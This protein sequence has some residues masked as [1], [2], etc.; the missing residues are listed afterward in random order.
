VIRAVQRRI[1]EHGTDQGGH[2][3]GPRVVC[4]MVDQRSSG[5]SAGVL[6]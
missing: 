1:S 6:G 2:G 3:G 5:V 4:E